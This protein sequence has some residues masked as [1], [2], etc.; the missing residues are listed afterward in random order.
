MCLERGGERRRRREISYTHTHTHTH[1]HTRTLAH[2]HAR[3]S[4]ERLLQQYLS[5]GGVH[6]G[7]NNGSSGDGLLGK[8]RY[9]TDRVA[10]SEAKAA[11]CSDTHALALLAVVVKKT[12]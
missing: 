6:K 8:K 12:K 7:V 4:Q 5:K 11:L 10:A 9:I 2:S 3:N 1:S